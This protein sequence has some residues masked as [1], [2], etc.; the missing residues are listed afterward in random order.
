MADPPNI[1]YAGSSAVATAVRVTTILTTAIQAIGDAPDDVRRV[2]NRVQEVRAAILRLPNPMQLSPATVGAQWPREWLVEAHRA[3]DATA[4]EAG[5]LHMRLSEWD[6]RRNARQLRMTWE[7]FH[8]VIPSGLLD[9][10]SRRI[11]SAKVAIEIL[12]SAVDL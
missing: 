12:I 1:S 9:T 3:I 4:A 6:L 11:E 10:A 2:L 7:A 5:G 8:L